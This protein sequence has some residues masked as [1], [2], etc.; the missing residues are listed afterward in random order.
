ME[1]I[2]KDIIGYEGR[3]TISNYGIIYSIP[4]PSTKGGIRIIHLDKG[5][6]YVNLRKDGKSG[7]NKFIHRL[8]AI[9]FLHN[10]EN[11][12]QVNHI[13]GNKLNNKSDNLEW[14]TAQ[15]NINHYISNSSKN[16]SSKF[17]GVCL[18]DGKWCA[19]YTFNGKRKHIGY[20]GTQ[21]EAYQ[22]KLD[23]MKTNNII[24]KY[25]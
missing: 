16:Y 5:Y 17:N 19:R 9:H 13:D 25:A 3:F 8:V 23:F 6:K 20:F 15:E 14:C 4:R 22:A 24:N 12:K 2:W 11:K 7:R 21:E 1:E 10:Y 18:K